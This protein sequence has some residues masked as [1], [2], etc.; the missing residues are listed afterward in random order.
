MLDNSSKTAYQIKH[1]LVGYFSINFAIFMKFILHS[2]RY[3]LMS[4]FLLILNTDATL[5]NI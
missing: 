3:E 2:R 4:I 5:K 1:F